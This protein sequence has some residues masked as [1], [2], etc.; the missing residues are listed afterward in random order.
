MN[1]ESTTATQP[2]SEPLIDLNNPPTSFAAFKPVGHVVIA[3]PDDESSQRAQQEL[4]D[5][6]FVRTQQVPST[7]MRSYMSNQLDMAGGSAEFGHEVVVMRRFLSMSAQ[8][9]G[10]LIVAADDDEAA[11]RVVELVKPLGAREAIKYGRL[12]ITDLL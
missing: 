7:T 11:K 10:W 6:G 12:V 9:W 2:S 1:A 3:F 8:G 4:A 5:K